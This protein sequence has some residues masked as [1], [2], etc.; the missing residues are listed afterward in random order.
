M[1]EEIQEINEIDIQEINEEKV[2]K[3]VSRW[4]HKLTDD[5]GEKEDI[6]GYEGDIED[7]ED[8][9]DIED[10]EEKVKEKKEEKAKK[11][12]EY[13]DLYSRRSTHVVIYR[14]TEQKENSISSRKKR[15]LVKMMIW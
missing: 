2:N 10:D 5:L 9:E 7:N 11:E 15:I 14:D 4:P 12:K 13:S 8:E 1:Q 3:K 6:E